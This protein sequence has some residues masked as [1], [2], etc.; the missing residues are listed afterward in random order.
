MKVSNN[1][2]AVMGVMFSLIM[3]N[4]VWAEEDVLTPRIERLERIIQGQGLVSLLGRVDQLQKE[5]QRLNGDN[6]SLRHQ[7]ETMKKN[8]RER[9]IDLDQRIEKLSAAPASIVPTMPNVSES[10]ASTENVP[11][12][13]PETPIEQVAPKVDAPTL[14]NASTPDAL[15]VA[16][17][18]GEA[19]YQAALQTLRS[20]QYEQAVTALE[21]FP[22][23][24]PGSSYLPNAYY[25]KG[26]AHYV[27]RN[28]DQ[29]ILAFT[30]VIKGFPASSKVAD[31]T[32][33][34]G[35][36]QYENGQFDVAKATLSSVIKNYPNTSAARLAQV[37]LDR[38][39][40][41]SN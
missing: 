12:V 39:N 29:A 28:F 27:L 30:K 10:V 32:L 38:I 18:N 31:A 7:I 5:V 40:K 25:W 2:L 21:A 37:R 16:V 36:S 17:E 3:S 9:Y 15:P 35:F 26:E 41:E 20:G 22:A 14:D 34:L 33:K 13:E 11:A 23:A 1:K 4:T 19:A 24:Y 8:Q 6:E